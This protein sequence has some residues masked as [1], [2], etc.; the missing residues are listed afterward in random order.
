MFAF[1]QYSN[2]KLLLGVDHF[3]EKPLYWYKNQD[4]FYFSSEPAP[5][6]SLFK[7]KI[8]SDPEKI[9]EFNMLGYL[10][11]DR[12]LIEG[13]FKCKPAHYLLVSKTLR[14]AL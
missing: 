9:L 8:T 13:L 7:L 11:E 1:A 6:V 14:S 10:G 4:G 12:S 5:L 2:G 3:G